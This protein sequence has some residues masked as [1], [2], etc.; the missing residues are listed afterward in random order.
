[1]SRDAYWL[2]VE[3][4]QI[5]MEMKN[6]FLIRA[7]LNSY[8]LALHIRN[9]TWNPKM[10]VWKMFF[11]SKWVHFRFHVSFLVCN[12]PRTDDWLI[13]LINDHY[14]SIPI[15]IHFCAKR[16]ISLISTSPLLC[17]SSAIV[18]TK[19]LSLYILFFRPHFPP[20]PTKKL[21]APVRGYENA[22]MAWLSGENIFGWKSGNSKGPRVGRFVPRLRWCMKTLHD[23]FQGLVHPGRLT[24]NLKMMV[25]KMIFLFQGVF[26][27][28]MLILLIL[29]GVFIYITKHLKKNNWFWNN[30]FCWRDKLI[31]NIYEYMY[32]TY[33]SIYLSM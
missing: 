5:T 1:M 15:D 6:S 18:H 23:F 21:M 22:V 28:S 16:N 31:T 10:K 14:L 25:W 26:S 33:T 9:W 13:W 27:G 30:H 2:V 20:T 7:Y 11:L 24:C 29:W 12:W 17:F 19:M 3:T 8:P 4:W 32:T